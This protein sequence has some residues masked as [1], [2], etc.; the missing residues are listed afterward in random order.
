MRA[1]SATL[2]PVDVADRVVELVGAMTVREIL[3]GHQSRAFEVRRKGDRLVVK[4]QDASMV[5]S[6]TARERV[7]VIAE[8]AA[9]DD[10]VCAPWPLDGRLT[11][12]LDDDDG[13][14]GLVTCYEYAAG[15][16]PDTSSRADAM[17]MGCCLARLH[18]SM[19]QL[20]PRSLPHVAALAAV[21]P[22]W[23]GPTQLL[24]G[25]FNAGNLRLTDGASRIFDFD[26]CGYGPVSFDVANAMY[27]VL[28][29]D[30]TGPGPSIYPS[31]TEAFLDGYGS[32]AQEPLDAD[33]LSMFV[34]LRVAALG[35]WLD[36]PHTAPIG[37]RNAQPSWRA[38]LRAFV[39]DYQRRHR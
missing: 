35:S 18:R 23:T 27:M 28:F 17:S 3:G 15:D 34:E 33:E 26:D 12:V 19:R 24:H 5:D 36:Q 14:T 13:W 7:D 2:W 10:Q 11:T 38:T 29:D 6:A 32:V 22:D 4:V 31:F 8:L 37:I 20:G 21:R 30:M 1:K 39:G 25:D 9:L 16:A